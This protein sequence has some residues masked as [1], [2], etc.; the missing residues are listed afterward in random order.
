[1]NYYIKE[2]NK[3]DLYDYMYVNIHAWNETYRGIMD[4]S[5]LDKIMLEL[6]EIVLKQQAKYEKTKLEEPDYRRFLLY[7]NDKPVGNF[8]ICKSTSEKY[9]DA[10]EI[11]SF[12]LLNIAKKQGYGRI[13]FNKAIDE[14]KEMNYK[15]MVISCLK[16]NPSKGFYEHMGGQLIYER[17]RFIGGKNLIENIYYYPQI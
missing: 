12:Y 1:M 3:N 16:D 5:F 17:T 9:P 2:I 14:V 13:M 7:V 10:G 11:R 8:S 6:D 15:D 4:D